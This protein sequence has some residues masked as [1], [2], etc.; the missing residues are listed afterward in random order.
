MTTSP[1]DP[2]YSSDTADFLAVGEAHTTSP[3]DERALYFAVTIS[4]ELYREIKQLQ[5]LIEGGLGIGG[6][7]SGAKIAIW[8]S[9]AVYSRAAPVYSGEPN[10]QLIEIRANIVPDDIRLELTSA[11]RVNVTEDSVWFSGYSRHGHDYFSSDA[12]PIEELDE[13]FRE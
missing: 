11:D 12:I 1:S 13:F 10:S 7:S 8:D 2:G 9:S 4:A 6:R 3:I 5:R